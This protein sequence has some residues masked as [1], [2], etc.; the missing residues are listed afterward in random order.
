LNKT[1]IERLKSLPKKL[2]TKIIGQ[3]D[4]IEAVTNSIMRS[5]A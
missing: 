2:E 1:E 5:S 3:K 4:A